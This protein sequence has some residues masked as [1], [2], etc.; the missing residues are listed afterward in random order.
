MYRDLC[1]APSPPPPHRRRHASPAAVAA[2]PATAMQPV[3]TPLPLR[4]FTV[5]RKQ[6]KARRGVIII[7]VP[8]VAAMQQG[9]MRSHMT[10]PPRPPTEEQWPP[11]RRRRHQPSP[12]GRRRLRR[13]LLPAPR[14]A[15][16]CTIYSSSAMVHIYCVYT[17]TTSSAFFPLARRSRRRRR[18]TSRVIA[19]RQSKIGTLVSPS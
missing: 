2:V 12:P 17:A 11:G 9:C 6:G 10:Q 7:A 4:W 1:L 15:P 3:N 5:I 16:P 14:P 18:R 13:P 19:P 8:A